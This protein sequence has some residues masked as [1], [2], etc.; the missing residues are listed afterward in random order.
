PHPR[1]TYAVADIEDRS[2][3]QRWEGEITKLTAVHSFNWLK[4][5]RRGFETVHG[6]LKRGG[7]AAFYFPLDGPYYDGMIVTGSD[8]K[9]RPYF[10]SAYYCVP[11]SYYNNYDSLHYRKML[12]DIGFK[13]IHCKDEMK[14]DIL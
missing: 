3:V 12:M 8:P 11:E 6:L 9:F 5:Q 10:Q 4:S 14:E 1:I 7:E 13:I 2:T